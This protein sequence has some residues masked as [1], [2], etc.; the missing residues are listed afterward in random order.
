[1]FFLKKTVK[2]HR[3]FRVLTVLYVQN[4]KLL[5]FK[6]IKRTVGSS[7]NVQVSYTFFF[8]NSTD[9][10]N[11]KIMHPAVFFTIEKEIGCGVNKTYAS[12][13]AYKKLR[14][15]TAQSE[16]ENITR[17]PT[18]WTI[19]PSATLNYPTVLADRCHLLNCNSFTQLV[20]YLLSV[21][22]Y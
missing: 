15:H 8:R 22:K 7:Y 9:C 14:Q 21:S 5:I 16:C 19:R 18:H 20:I 2:F 17:H 4:D 13:V 6:M 1:M 11:I 3:V 10:D 12:Q